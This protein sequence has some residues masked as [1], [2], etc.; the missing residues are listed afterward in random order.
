MS[1]P[2]LPAPVTE[3]PVPVARN[4]GTSRG[5]KWIFRFVFLPTLGLG[6]LVWFA[7]MIVATT[8]LRQ[9]IPRLLFPTYPGKVEVGAASFGWF[10]PVV[11]RDLHFKNAEGHPLLDIREISSSEPLWKLMTGRSNL[12]RLKVVEPN[13]LKFAVPLLADT[14]QIDG[15][16]SL[17]LTGGARPLASPK[18][19]ELDGVLG[20]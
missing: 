14:T 19:G 11:V 8:A 16:F 18:S 20:P 7:P 9:R 17:E 1:Q 12:G 10:L 15:E 2:P 5:R 13:F 4:A 6:I 3:S